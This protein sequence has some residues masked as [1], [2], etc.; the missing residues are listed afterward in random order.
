MDDA[1]ADLLSSNPKSTDGVRENA[2]AMAASA[3]ASTVVNGLGVV[4][5]LLDVLHRENIAYCH[6]KSNE[7]V[8]EG[9]A[10]LTD[11]DI[12]VD[13]DSVPELIPCLNAAGFKRFCAVPANAYPAVE[14][15]L[16]M[17]D[18]T[19]KLV[20]L[21]LHYQLI[22]GEPHLKGYRLPWEHL[23]LSTRKFDSQNGIYIADPNLEI[24]L[25]MVRAVLKLRARDRLL[26]VLGK[27][28]FRGDLLREYGWLKERIEPEMV[29]KLGRE[30]LNESAA[31]SLN[32]LIS[33]AP[34]FRQLLDF[35]GHAISVL[36]LYRT[37]NSFSAHLLRWM[38][39]LY[40][41]AGV[42]NKRY[43]HAPI[44]LRRIPAKGGAVIAFVGCDGSGKSTHAKE[45]VRWLSWKLDVVPMYFGS[46]DGPGS[47]LRLPMNWAAALLRNMPGF[48]TQ[49][50]RPKEGG[51]RDAENVTPMDPWPKRMARIPWALALAREKAGKL[52]A[53]IR[54]RNRGM[55]VICDRYP[56]TQILGFND[57]P[58]LSRWLNH[59]LAL[60]R[61]LAG[62]ER[63]PYAR[64]EKY[65][66]DLLIK[67]NVTPEVALRRKPDTARI[68]E[69]RRRVAAIGS[70]HFP[71]PTKTVEIDAD[72]SFEEV[73][74]QIRKCIWDAL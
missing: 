39:E 44:P 31:H 13:R 41:A 65:P 70:L 30:L 64:A 42:I 9:M 68:E 40:W 8:R 69:C 21:H 11:L 74:A 54:A 16:A 43:I 45:I 60:L 49:W 15:Y 2:M 58:L 17:D 48:R 62:L 55:I 36:G 24:I 26:S 52:R 59:P 25:L 67:L 10:G 1:K 7:H 23:I 29:V 73:L 53:T 71:P 4:A 47:L 38:R 14:D 66:P 56:Q 46:G 61:T 57:G 50:N 12:L 5:N 51:S 27:P 33:G 35:R 37:F 20:H 18:E 28:Y 19:G 72:Q 32:A 3:K 6:W 63:A 22:L 34:S